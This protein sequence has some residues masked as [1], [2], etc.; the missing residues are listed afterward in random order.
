MSKL[1]MPWSDV[2]EIVVTATCVYF[3]VVALARIF[4]QR[5]FSRLT[6]YDL[7]F[8]FALG[9]LVGRVILV[10]TTLAAA[11]VGI[12]TMFALHTGSGWLHHHVPFVHQLLENRPVLLVAHGRMIDEN[13]RRARTSA[14]EVHEKLRLSGV[15]SIDQVQAAILE[16]TGDI[17]IIT[18]SQ[19]VDP[20]MFDDV[21]GIEE[22]TRVS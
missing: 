12:L 2:W 15:G 10:R 18:S 22:L 7:P 20:S 14:L 19:D 21:W 16:R 3:A 8:V 11:L 17:S 6:A 9:S 13:I 4:G 1:G 5:Q